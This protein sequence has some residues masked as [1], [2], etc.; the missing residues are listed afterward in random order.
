MVADRPAAEAGGEVGEADA[1]QIGS[2]S[3]RVP[4]ATSRRRR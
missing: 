1:P 4:A 2:T 3:M